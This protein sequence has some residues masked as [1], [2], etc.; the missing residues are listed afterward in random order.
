MPQNCTILVVEDDELI[1]ETLCDCLE[2][3]GFDVTCCDNGL[4][5]LETAREKCFRVIITDHDLPG[6]SGAEIVRTLRLQCPSSFIIGASAGRKEKDFL[7]AGVDIY[8][9]KPYSFLKLADLVRNS[10]K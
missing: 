8:L 4:T 6:I 2:A 7:D 10:C 1:L 9:H 3:E 5:A